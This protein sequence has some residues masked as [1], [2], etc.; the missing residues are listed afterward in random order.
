LL[1]TETRA[2][3]RAF[4]F[5]YLARFS[6]QQQTSLTPP[7]LP[8]EPS[9]KKHIHKQTMYPVQSSFL[10]LLA[11]FGLTA[12]GGSA[13]SSSSTARGKRRLSTE[14]LPPAYEE[15]GKSFNEKG[16]YPQDPLYRQYIVSAY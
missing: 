7:P 8:N 13:E 15:E 16:N 14:T 9:T 6:T 3:R 2:V 12:A 5:A 4:V 1:A 10:L 11:L